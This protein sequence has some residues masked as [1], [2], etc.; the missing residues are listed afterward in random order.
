MAIGF[1]FH[2]DITYIL[3]D[4]YSKVLAQM[5]IQNAHAGQGLANVRGIQSG[6]QPTA[7][8]VV[9]NVK[10]VYVWARTF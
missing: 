5:T 7:K 4:M 9:K 1:E 2:N 3:L 10:L 8:R 6:C